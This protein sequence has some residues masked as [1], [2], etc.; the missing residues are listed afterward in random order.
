M[1]IIAE[2]QR[3][4]QELVALRRDFHAHPEL[5]FE[6][7]RT[8]ER[9]AEYLTQ[10]GI[11][12][13]TGVAKTGVVGLIR[14]E[15]DGRTVMLRSDMDALPITEETGL[16]FASENE[17][18]MHACGHDGHMAMLLVAAKV[19]SRHRDRIRG[20]VKLVFQPNEE[21][22][23]AEPMVEEGV[24]DDPPVDGAFGL[25]L[26]SPLSTGTIG[27][28]EGPVMAS[29]YYFTLTIRGQ[30][31][32]GGAP[33][34]AVDPIACAT[35][36]MQTVQNVQT[37]RVD[38]VYEPTVI[39]FGSIHGGNSPI[40]I[41]DRVTL[42]GSIRCLHDR[43]A[44]V[45]EMFGRVVKTECEAAGAEY[46]ISYKCGNK[47]LANDPDMTR[48][49]EEV[50]ASYPE[51]QL[52]LERRVKVMLGEDFAEF[53]LRVPSA[54]SF[55]GTAREEAGSTYPHHHPRFTIDEASL[56]IG[57][58]MHVQTALAFLSAGV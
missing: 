14:G 21:D 29:S 36:I 1:E 39:T 4:Q 6:E 17:G 5:G 52:S 27:I 11:E 44:E 41:P 12:V 13:R 57:A 28:A 31:G 46:E 50:T 34:L 51:E 37:R 15:Q 19:L 7:Y 20:A 23:G 40:V 2:I 38:A 25:H 24:L 8:A 32:H 16:P 43:D 9:V 56:P 42:G 45:R 33:H 35:N 53:A 48:I 55:V 30:G 3:E 18:V 26:W 10:C 49:V 54:F 22:A 47:L 58:A